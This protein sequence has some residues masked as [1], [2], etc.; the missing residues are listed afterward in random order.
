MK[1][2]TLR[3]GYC[4][5]KTMSLPIELAEFL[6]SKDPSELYNSIRT[7]SGDEWLGFCFWSLH[8]VEESLDKRAE[9]D[10]DDRLIP[11]Y[12]DWHN[13]FCL[14]SSSISYEVVAIDDDRNVVRKWKSFSTFKESLFWRDAESVNDSGIIA[15]ESWLDV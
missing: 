5:V 9:W 13:L 3:D 10:V 4:G 15:D 2:S 12:G 11:F 8:E 1:K 7:A 14:N 6:G